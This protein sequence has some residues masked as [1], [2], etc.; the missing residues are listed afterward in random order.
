MKHLRLLILLIGTASLAQSVSWTGNAGNQDFFDEN[1]WVDANTNSIPPQGS[2]NPNTAINFNL[3]VEN[4][5]TNIEANGIINLG[6]SALSISNAAL[7]ATAI[8]G[9]QVG[10]HSEAYINLSANNALQNNVEV[11]FTSPVA[12]LKMLNVNPVTV[13]NNYVS[14]FSI[15]DD[16]AVYQTNLRI[17]NY[18]ENGSVVRSS[19]DADGPLLLYSDTNLQGNMAELNVDVIY[20]GSEIPNNLNN[21]TSSFVLK[22]GYMATLADN[23][24]GTGK[25]KN[26]IAVEEDLVIDEIPNFINNKISFIRVLPWNWVSKKGR[27]GGGTSTLLNNTWFYHWNNN[28]NSTLAL[29]YAPMSWGA[30]GANSDAAIQNYLT[31]DKS[32][33]VLAFNESDNCDD[34]SGQY[35]D[36]CQVPVAVGLYENLMKTGMRLVSPN[37]RENAPFGWLLDFYNLANQNDIRIDVIGVHWYDWGSNPQN[38]PNAN[39]N[40]IFQ[41]FQNYLQNVYDLYGLPIWITEFNANP[42]RTNQVNYEFMQLALPYLESLDYVERYAWFEPF[43]DVADYTDAN[44]NLTNVGNFYTNQ[45][46]T[47]AVAESTWTENNNIEN[48]LVIVDPTGEN[49]IVNGFFETGDLFGWEG[50]NIGILTN[51]NSNI[52]NGTTSGR[53]LANAGELYQVIEVEPNT[54]YEVSL[55]NK[56]FVPPSEAVDIKIINTTD[57]SIIATQ[58]T[59]TNTN[60]NQL[61][62]EFIT[63]SNVT[64]IK[65]IIEK[66][67]E[68]GWFID[69]AVMLKLETLSTYQLNTEEGIVIFPNPSSASIEVRTSQNIKSI[70]VVNLRGQ[71]VEEFL[72]INDKET[73]LNVSKLNNGT[74]ILQINTHTGK[75]FSKKI[76]IQ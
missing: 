18:Y 21:T 11:D 45:V 71:V 12:W 47:P 29:E 51:N 9:G 41:R 3:T 17:D 74:Y 56:W 33:N 39:P 19:K 55:Y 69:D 38:S 20:S 62:F 52:Y 28:M 40:Q 49:L 76:I 26:Y 66:G 64:E 22:K 25:S 59:T 73:V 2:I 6:T 54:V 46:S 68:P 48:Y 31:K 67:N 72:N 36:L 53:I 75:S 32:T 30:G 42:N 34:Q 63:P 27:G 13:S 58:P 16:T 60:W 1:N 14:Q 57:N 5:S 61:E 44:G 37:G 70:R 8:S 23:E 15:D 7:N 10:L 24:D 4:V 35:N 65:F 43:S 50:S